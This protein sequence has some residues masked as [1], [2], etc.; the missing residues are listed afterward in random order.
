[1][2]IPIHGLNHITFS[3]SDLDA[4]LAF[5]QGVFEAKLLLRQERTAY[6]D[7]CGLWLALNVEADIPRQEIKRSYTH[8][9]FTIAPADVLPMQQRLERLSVALRPSR[10]RD[11]GEGQSLYFAD[12]D[13]HLFEF[14][15]DTLANRL[16]AYGMEHK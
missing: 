5:Y 16:Q 10:V 13:G 9:A 1:M 8:L 4:A 3:V 11:E 12:P 7:L 14:H 6:L 15:A 2:T